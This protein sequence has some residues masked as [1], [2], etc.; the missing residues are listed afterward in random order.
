MILGDKISNLRKQNGW[1]QEELAE[2]LNISRQSVSKW[3][4]GTS[5][6]D[7]DKIVKL[8]GIFGVSTD[9]LLKDEL[10]VITPSESDVDYQ[11]ESLTKLSLEEATEYMN[12]VSKVSKWIGLGVVL[13]ILGPAAM[14][15]LL[16]FSIETDS[17]RVLTEEAAG[18]LGLAILLILVAAGV[19]LLITHGMKLSKYEYLEKETF[20]LEY[21]VYGIV[22]K[23]KEAFETAFRRS[24]TLG[25][26]LCIISV[27]PIMLAVA[28]N[29]NEQTYIW[30]T[31]ILLIFVALGVF[32]FI[33]SGEIRS[34]Y[35]KILQVGDFSPENKE[36]EKHLSWFPGVY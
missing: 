3:E 31:S 22:E 34:S 28:V 17:T 24:V 2:K 30:C 32:L 11:K 5:I 13:C 25:V 1:S 16:G 26:I 8:S 10:E 6:P 21:G 35:D 27:V 14:I 19:A 15:G 23:K 18:G 7:L 36:A 20:T 33:W 9:Y 12:V 29:A 4:S